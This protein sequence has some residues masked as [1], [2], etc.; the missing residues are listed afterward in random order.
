MKW[1]VADPVVAKIKIANK[2]L[3]SRRKRNN[4]RYGVSMGSG[5]SLYGPPS[6]LGWDCIPA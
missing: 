4:L 1:V 6:T 5:L 3:L 2:K